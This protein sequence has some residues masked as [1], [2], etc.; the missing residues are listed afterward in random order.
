[1]ELKKNREF[2]PP[3]RDEVQ[4]GLICIGNKRCPGEGERRRAMRGISYWDCFCG[5]DGAE[6]WSGAIGVVVN[7][8]SLAFTEHGTEAIGQSA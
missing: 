3:T 2:N 4:R 6:G 5:I 7:V 1:M 8:D